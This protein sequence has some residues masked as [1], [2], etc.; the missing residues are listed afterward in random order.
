MR[1]LLLEDDPDQLSIARHW[2]EEHG[3]AVHGF[4]NGDEA[5]KAIERD[6]FDLAILD[7]MVP[8]TNGEAVLLWIRKRDKRMPVVFATARDEEDEIVHIL[9]VGADDYVV[10]PLRRREFVARV[11]ALGRRSG[12]TQRAVQPFEVGPYRIDPAKRS[13][14]LA[15]QV[16][17]MTPRMFAVAILL[18][19]KH[20]ELV[21][22]GQIYEEAW[23]RRE[24]PD[25][26]TVDT[27]VSRLRTALELDGRHGWKLSSV[28]QLGYRLEEVDR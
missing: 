22:R 26:R 27:H 16:V 8:G 20:G 10:K 28:Y 6:R 7:W 1:I 2:L 9:G 24:Q 17:K 19:R 5:I 25:T 18:F 12:E 4:A 14:A 3:H 11:E 21:S 23:G 15:G 13:V